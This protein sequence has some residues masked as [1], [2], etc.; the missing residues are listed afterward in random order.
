MNMLINFING[1][2]VHCKHEG[3]VP[4]SWS[5]LYDKNMKCSKCK[6]K[7]YKTNTKTGNIKGCN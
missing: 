4:A 7:F 6:K 3:L 1:K 2:C 5:V